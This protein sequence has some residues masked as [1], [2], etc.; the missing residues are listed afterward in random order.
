MFYC[1]EEGFVYDDV[2]G[3]CVGDE[4]CIIFCFVDFFNFNC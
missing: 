2:E 1:C 4:V 3:W